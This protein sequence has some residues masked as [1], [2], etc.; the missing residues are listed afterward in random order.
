MSAYRRCQSRVSVGAVH[1]IGTVMEVETPAACAGTAVERMTRKMGTDPREFRGEN[2]S[3]A[4]RMENAVTMR[5]A[6]TAVAIVMI[7][8]GN[9]ES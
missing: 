7:A 9:T 2:T 6:L 1:G 5:I 8:V 3:T 4:A